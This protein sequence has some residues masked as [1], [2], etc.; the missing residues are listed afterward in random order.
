MDREE[1]LK[2]VTDAI[3]GN[4]LIQKLIKVCD[5][6]EKDEEEATAEPEKL[7]KEDAEAQADKAA[8]KR[9]REE[10]DVSK[11]SKTERLRVERDEFAIKLSKVEKEREA[12]REVMA[13]L[14]RKFRKTERE[15]E[16]AQLR[17]EG[18]AF[19]LPAE[20]EYVLDMPEEAWE[21]HKGVIKTRYQK[22]PL[23]MAPIPTAKLDTIGGKKGIDKEQM[24][25]AVKYSLANKVSYEEAWQRLSAAS[26]PQHRRVRSQET[27]DKQCQARI[28]SPVGT[29]TRACLLRRWRGTISPFCNRRLATCP[30][31]FQTKARFT[32]TR[33]SPRATPMP[34]SPANQSGSM[35]SAKSAA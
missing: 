25:K 30:S 9:E 26:E 18:F 12:D 4:P 6:M 28:L 2:C 13:E 33:L 34:V 3:N 7:D 21:A 10:E 1:I 24:E 22:A 14:Q 5:L 20:L 19:E 8:E 29:S 35:A 17:Y 15:K 11:M 31:A 32:R 27:E 23:G 16:L